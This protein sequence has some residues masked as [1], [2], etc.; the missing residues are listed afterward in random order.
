M[1]QSL[2]NKLPF[3]IIFSHILP[4]TYSPQNKELLQDIKHYVISKNEISNIY[5]NRYIIEWSESE[6]EDKYWIINDIVEFMNGYQESYFGYT[7][8]FYDI[9][10]RIPLLQKR[11]TVNNYFNL[12]ENKDINTQINILW[13]LFTPEERDIFISKFF[14]M[15]KFF[16]ST[17]VQ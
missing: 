15:S 12:I 2:M 17:I 5:Y 8:G 14:F 1:K 13:G 3:D 10:F 6:P 11:K 4:F 16:Q 7:D 9:F